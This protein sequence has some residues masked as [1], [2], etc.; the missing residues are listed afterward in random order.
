L[1]RSPGFN[2]FFPKK[3]DGSHGHS[4]IDDHRRV[5]QRFR[6]TR[7]LFDANDVPRL[8]ELPR[9]QDEKG[10]AHIDV[11]VGACPPEFMADLVRR[12]QAVTTKPLFIDTPDP[13]IAEA[14]LRAYDPERAGGAPPVLNS[15]SP[16]RLGMFDLWEEK[17][18]KVMEAGWTVCITDNPMGLLS[19]GAT[20]TIE[21]LGLPVEPGRLLVHLNTFHTRKELDD[22]LSATLALGARDLLVVSGDGSQRLHRPEPAEI[23]VDA[24]TVT[25]V[26]L[27][28]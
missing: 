4:R 2:I 3:E 5:H 19:Y 12:I 6:S 1:K 26:E 18:H 20:E 16:L 25:S 24:L 28:R 7:K 10:A 17:Y 21:L 15:I 13:A 8:L 27:L 22:I 9:S 11:N 23:G 14:G